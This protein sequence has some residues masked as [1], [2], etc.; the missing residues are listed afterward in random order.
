MNKKHTKK[1]ALAV[2]WVLVLIVWTLWNQH[3]EHSSPSSHHG[4]GK[5]QAESSSAGGDT[6]L[7]F[8]AVNDFTLAISWQP[9]FCDSRKQRPEC[10]HSST[11]LALHGFWP[12]V[13][14]ELAQ[15]GV[16]RHTWNSEGCFAVDHQ[17]SGSFCSFSK[18]ELQRSTSSALAKA[19]PGEQSCLDRHEYAKHGACFNIS[20]DQYFGHAIKL[21]DAVNDSRFGQWLADHRGQQV[22]RQDILSTFGSTFHTSSKALMLMC[23]R[24]DRL[25][26]LRIGINGNQLDKFPASGSFGKAG[27]GR[28]GQNV[29]L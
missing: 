23:D 12:G 5:Q 19:M 26:E 24:D 4:G 22:A 8:A 18:P 3:G 1:I 11:T 9:G 15:R 13:P 14:K 21:F 27:N 20:A 28:C 29:S 25:T 7:D 17:H 10:R 2:V 16:N 6:P